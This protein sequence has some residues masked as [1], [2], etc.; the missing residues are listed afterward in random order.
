MQCRI[1]NPKN[2][3]GAQRFVIRR[4]ARCWRDVGWLLLLTAW[5]PAFGQSSVL[6]TSFKVGPGA[7]VAVDSLVVQADQR[8]LVGGEFTTIG[9]GSNSFLARLNSDGSVDASFNPSGQT[10]GSVE[11]LL[12]QPDRKVLVGGSFGR[13]LGHSQPAL[14]RLLADGSV[15]ATFDASATFTTNSSIF[16][17]ALQVDGRL[18]VGY[19]ASDEY[20]S[21]VVRINTNGTLDPTFVCT[22]KIY[23][24]VFALLPQADGSVL[25]GGNFMGIIGSTNY[26]LFRLAPDGRFDDTFDAGLAMSSVFCLVRQPGGQILVGGLLNRTGASNS[27]PLLRLTPDLQWDESFKID[28]LGGVGGGGYMDP[29]VSALL[30]QPDGKM[31]IGGFFMEAAGYCRREIVRLT[32]EGHVDGCFD[33]GLGLGGNE[34]AGPVRALV[35]QPDGRVLIGGVFQGVDTAYGQ[36]NL[37]RLLPQSD[38]DSIH[39]YLRGGDQTFAAATFPPGRTNYLEQSNDLKNWQA[40]ETNTSPYIFYLN[41][42]I[43]DP[44]PTFFRARQE[45]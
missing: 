37:A 45:R 5:T 12:Q 24:Y 9:G 43:S 41:F 23:G 18:L 35:L 32:A 21:H 27:A 29:S 14:A 8:I 20:A 16:S 25:F 30:L 13:L 6:D 17:L 1:R 19:L 7:N 4:A 22:N 39:V 40:V 38:C 26:A 33:P 31:V 44:A 10:D 34:R 3:R 42:S 15:D 36:F 2:E 11:C 28:A